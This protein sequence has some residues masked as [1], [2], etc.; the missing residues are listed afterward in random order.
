MAFGLVGSFL[1][2]LLLFFSP[3][4]LYRYRLNI[5]KNCDNSVYK[6]TIQMPCTRPLGGCLPIC[7][8]ISTKFECNKND[9]F[10]IC[11]GLNKST[12][13]YSKDVSTRMPRV[14]Q[15]KIN[16]WRNLFYTGTY[17]HSPI[18]DWDL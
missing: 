5:P 7:Y 6:G 9:C 13:A 8:G 16:F 2:V 12:C 17:K 1:I 10:A 4:V 11:F 3:S 18:R 15:M 14:I